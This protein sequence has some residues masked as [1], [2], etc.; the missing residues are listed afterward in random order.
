MFV[1]RVEQ[2]RNLTMRHIHTPRERLGRWFAILCVGKRWWRCCR[3]SSMRHI[4]GPLAIVD[5]ATEIQTMGQ[6]LRRGRRREKRFCIVFA[7]LIYMIT[8]TVECTEERRVGLPSSPLIA[9][10]LTT[11]RRQSKREACWAGGNRV[12][13]RK[14]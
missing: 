9:E 13:R 11:L 5:Y 4:A 1:E 3:R 7:K 14:I 10:T 2:A 6:F 12:S 8:K